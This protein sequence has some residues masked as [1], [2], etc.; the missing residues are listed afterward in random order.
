VDGCAA[1][2]LAASELSE[3]LGGL[4]D[5]TS[6]VATAVSFVEADEEGAR[7]WPAIGLAADGLPQPLIVPTT[8]AAKMQTNDQHRASIP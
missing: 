2:A 3:L 5:A 8:Q 6:S 1:G 4:S 7:A